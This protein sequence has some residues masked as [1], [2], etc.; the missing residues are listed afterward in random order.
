MVEQP[1]NS[2]YKNINDLSLIKPFDPAFAINDKKKN[3]KGLIKKIILLF[4]LLVAII[5]VPYCGSY[6]DAFIFEYPF[7]FGKYL[8][9]AYMITLISLW[10]ISDEW[11]S[12]FT[13]FGFIILILLIII[14]ISIMISAISSIVFENTVWIKI[15]NSNVNESDFILRLSYFHK[16]F[17]IPYAIKNTLFYT[18]K[19]LNNLWFMNT[20]MTLSEINQNFG[21]IISGGIIGEFVNA[22]NYWIIIFFSLI[23]IIVVITSFIKNSNTKFGALF[24]KKIMKL[25]SNNE[26]NFKKNDFNTVIKQKQLEDKNINF[27]NK[28]DINTPPLSF[29]VDTSD[30]NDRYNQ[31]D[32]NKTLYAISQII[33]SSNLNVKFNTMNIM[34]MFTEI[35]FRANR[36]EDVEKFIKKSNEI[37]KILGLSQFYILMKGNNIT[38]EYQN[39]K[40]SKISI[41]STLVNNSIGNNM[42]YA[43]VGIDENKNPLFIDYK[44]DS[45]IFI[46]G[47]KGSGI[48]ML[49]SCLL[50]TSAYISSP[51]FLSID[52]ITGNKNSAIQSLATIPHIGEMIWNNSSNDIKKLLDKYVNEIKARKI[53]LTS[54]KVKDQKSFNDICDKLNIQPMITKV[55]VI[56][57]FDEI[58]KDNLE[59]ISKIAYILQ[60][61]NKLGICVILTASEFDN[62]NLNMSIFE[63]IKSIFVLKTDSKDSS[64]QLIGNARAS[65]L[66]GNGDGYLIGNNKKNK[67]RFQTC[68]LNQDELSNIVKIIIDFY[69]SKK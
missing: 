1:T 26:D 68:Y 29:L 35:K 23:L 16:N 7:G 64:L 47:K 61:C 2:T 15:Y 24:H 46:I 57:N 48:N 66:Y 4:I 51:I 45:S 52:I 67:L 54:Y 32:A 37:G 63:S 18:Y 5:R 12:K 25:F 19:G 17:F 38:F 59:C 69:K 49:L 3:P 36:N 42:C 39:Y 44:L 31:N 50:I 53:K 13:K 20:R 34:P 55:L 58:I 9:Y 27:Q 62:N 6:I 30:D 21:F 60:H 14:L 22:S 8:L 65:Q 11:F 33:K 40:P 43:I 10:I 41:K 56:N 28:F